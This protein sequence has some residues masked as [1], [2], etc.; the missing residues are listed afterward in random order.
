MVK[1]IGRRSTQALRG[2]VVDDAPGDR[3]GS[4][5][6]VRRVLTLG[7]V[8]SER[9]RRGSVEAGFAARAA[10]TPHGLGRRGPGQAV[11]PGRAR[12][13]AAGDGRR[14][15]GVVR[16]R[17]GRRARAPGGDG[18]ARRRRRRAAAARRRSHLER[19]PDGP[20][21]ARRRPG[22]RKGT[23][24][25]PA[26]TRPRRAPPGPARSTSRAR[27][28]LTTTFVP[29]ERTPNARTPKTSPD[30]LDQTFIYR[31]TPTASRRVRPRESPRG[32]DVWRAAR[33]RVT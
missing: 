10:G 21:G 4:P 3:S 30:R 13:G 18:L 1:L 14:A 22:P 17:V 20:P 27:T 16:R 7:R 33:P 2:G 8:S 15:R 19:L 26:R 31:T 32:A 6:R 11:A 25:I 28:R 24:G 12:R 5:G 29:N 9:H 23:L